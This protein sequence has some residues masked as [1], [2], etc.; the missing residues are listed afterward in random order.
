MKKMRA[1]L[2]MALAMSLLVSGCGKAAS[3]ET[4][5]SIEETQTEVEQ[6]EASEAEETAET[7]QTSTEET[8]EATGGYIDLSATYGRTMINAGGPMYM[9]HVVGGPNGSGSASAGEWGVFIFPECEI[10]VTDWVAEYDALEGRDMYQPVYEYTYPVT[11]TGSGYEFICT[12]CYPDIVSSEGSLSGRNYTLVSQ[13]DNAASGTNLHVSCTYEDEQGNTYISAG[14]LDATE[15]SCIYDENGNAAYAVYENVTFYVSYEQAGD[16]YD[17]FIGPALD[18]TIEQ[19]DYNLANCYK[20]LFDE[21][22]VITC[23]NSDGTRG[24]AGE[25]AWYYPA[26]PGLYSGFDGMAQLYVVQHDYEFLSINAPDVLVLFD[27]P[28]TFTDVTGGRPSDG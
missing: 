24:I 21:N 23:L 28:V 18:G 14:L 8:S 16:L 11:D 26:E 4:E 6:T 27:V 12:V 1:G 13:E 17:A 7:A 15:E 19:F 22:G 25:Y 5:G 10:T 9:E 2:C 3:E 20:V